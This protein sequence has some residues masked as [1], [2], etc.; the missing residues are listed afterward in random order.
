M[1]TWRWLAVTIIGALALLGLA[2]SG[3]LADTYSYDTHGRLV[4][5]IYSNGSTVTYTYDA[6]GN[7]TAVSQTP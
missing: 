5:V 6:A 2:W 7:R 4:G 1:G 3:A